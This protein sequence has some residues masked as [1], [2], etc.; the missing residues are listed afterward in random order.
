MAFLTPPSSTVPGLYSI[1][2]TCLNV[3]T[4]QLL[5]ATRTHEQLQDGNLVANTLKPETQGAFLECLGGN[6]N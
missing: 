3:I 2:S 6:L 5:S 4:P 1:L